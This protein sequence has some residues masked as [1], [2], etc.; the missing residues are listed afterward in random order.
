M[1]KR[2][3]NTSRKT[4]RSPRAI[5]SVLVAVGACISQPVA[6]TG[7]GKSVSLSIT[8]VD[9]P[10]TI[11]KAMVLDVTLTPNEGEPVVVP[12]VLVPGGTLSIDVV[13]A[14]GRTLV[15]RGPEY[16]LKPFTSANFVALGRDYFLGRRIRLDRLYTLE[17]P[18]EY[19]IRAHFRNTDTGDRFGL[20]A[21]TGV[22]SAA[23]IEIFV[24]EP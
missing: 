21:W 24:Q 20:T 11:G 3:T 8:P 2:S 5:L 13:G 18:G 17:A 4:I 9:P 10:F 19:R 6:E 12:A 23:E 7:M 15:Y 1:T 14:D 22:V 16:K